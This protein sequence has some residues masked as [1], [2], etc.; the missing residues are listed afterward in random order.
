MKRLDCSWGSNGDD[1]I[2]LLLVIAIV[3]ALALAVVSLWWSGWVV[4]LATGA[5]L[6]WMFGRRRALRSH[7][8]S[9]KYSGG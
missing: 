7:S 9:L 2:V 6:M 3:A 1:A 4:G 8:S 5:F